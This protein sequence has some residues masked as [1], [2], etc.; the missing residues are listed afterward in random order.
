MPLDE[1]SICGDKPI[2]QSSGM[3]PDSS[4]VGSTVMQSNCLH[5]LF[6]AQV[7]ISPDAIAVCDHTSKLTYRKLNERANQLAHYLRRQGVGPDVLVGIC[8]D[9]TP[10]LVVGVLAI[11]KAGGAYL[12]V[13][14]TYPKD[15]IAFVLSDAKAPLL[16]TQKGQATGLSGN[17]PRVV[18]VD[19]EARAIAAESVEN[20]TSEATSDNLAYVIYTS[21]STGKP[22]GVQIEHRAVVNFLNSM[23]REP[24]LTSRDTL[25][26]VT[27]LSFDIAGLELH[28]PLTTGARIVIVPR[29]TA[30]DGS[31]LVKII[32]QQNVTMLQATPATWRIMLAAGWEGTPGMKALCGGEPLPPELARELILRCAELWNM[33]GPTETTIW[34][35]CARIRDANHI[36]IGSPIDNTTI[37]IVDS[38]MAPVPV[39][40]PGE[41]LIG[42]EGLARGYVNRPE[43][44][45]E[46]FIAH[47]TVKG[48]R[49]YRTGDLARLLAN[50]EVECLGRLDFQVK[51]RGY[52]IELGEIEAVL[53]SHPC[54]LQAVVMAREDIPG[55]KR[56]VAYLTTR[57][58]ALFSVSEVREHARAKLPDYMLPAAFV[59]LEAIPL[60]PNGKIDRKQLPAPGTSVLTTSNYE[61]PPANTLEQRLASIWGRVLSLPSVGRHQSF[62]DLGG[63]SLLAVAVFADIEKQFARRLPLAVLFDHP[64][65]AGLAEYLNTTEP[66]G[67]AWPSLIPIHAQGT[68]QRIFCVHGAGGNILL[69]RTLVAQ[70]GEDYPFYGFQSHGLDG[71][72]P[73][74]RTI[75]EMASSYVTELQRLQPH[76]PYCLG[77]YCL[78]GAIALEMARLLL[79]KNEQVPLIAMFDCYNPALA[80]ETSRLRDIAQLLKFH[81][82]NFLRLRPAEMRSYLKEKIRVARDGQFKAVLGLTEEGRPP[83][84][85]KAGVDSG[86]VLQNIQANNDHAISVYQPTPFAGRL[87]LFKPK[88]NYSAYPDPL[89]GWSAVA[90][91]GVELV[92][93]PVNPHAMLVEPFVQHLALTLMTK[94]DEVKLPTRA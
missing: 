6:E 51:L 28:L 46:K 10:E 77:G 8:L 64:T 31:A 61:A 76:G 48:Q 70:M 91:G 26:A 3:P 50:G 81:L 5:Q 65:I 74:L 22:K 47:P 24:G 25:L 45:A 93:L 49:L 40:T 33:Y 89:M 94:L 20:P 30:V 72:E 55:D 12:P 36:T 88:T 87:T 69:Y 4:R 13:D 54:V 68:K 58:G 52:R 37:L 18:S 57:P 34:S 73:P 14:L 80:L 41:L 71:K 32:Q 82:S 75:E 84:L 7:A 19:E 29:Q 15:R 63:N 43:L 56:L 59:V 44:T 16:L 39:G 92:E 42:G 35:T 90:L 11:L 21:G 62:F 86:N 66:T 1:G 53:A 9:R 27:T 17:Q 23:R 79:Q 2:E 60:T 78:G 67:R 85:S 83:T 38:Q